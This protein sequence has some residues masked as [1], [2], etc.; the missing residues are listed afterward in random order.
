MRHPLGVP[1]LLVLLACAS[2]SLGA[3][4]EGYRVAGIMAVGGD[5][6]AL[7]IGFTPEG[8]G[9]RCQGSRGRVEHW[10]TEANTGT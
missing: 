9:A 8:P 5:Y 7:S 3:S 10:N 2:V 6:L 4:G 1:L